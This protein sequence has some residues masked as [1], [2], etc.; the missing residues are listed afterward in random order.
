[1]VVQNKIES[2][3]FPA[4]QPTLSP[5][6]LALKMLNLRALADY[7]MRGNNNLKPILDAVN[8]ST[9]AGLLG[10]SRVKILN[11]AAPLDRKIKS[12]ARNISI[13][14]RYDRDS[15][16]FEGVLDIKNPKDSS[17]LTKR[18]MRNVDSFNC[19]FHEQKR[20]FERLFL[21]QGDNIGLFL[22]KESQD[23]FAELNAHVKQSK[24][25]HYGE[26]VK[27]QLR[28]ATLAYNFLSEFLFKSIDEADVAP[29]LI[30]EPAPYPKSQ[31]IPTSPHELLWCMDAFEYDEAIYQKDSLYSLSETRQT[32]VQMFHQLKGY[33]RSLTADIEH[34][35]GDGWFFDSKNPHTR[36]FMSKNDLPIDVLVQYIKDFSDIMYD[37]LPLEE[38]VTL[39]STT[40]QYFDAY[41]VGIFEDRDNSLCAKV[42]NFDHNVSQYKDSWLPSVTP[43]SVTDVLSFLH[44]K[45][46]AKGLSKEF[47]QVRQLVTSPPEGF[48]AEVTLNIPQEHGVSHARRRWFSKGSMTHNV[49]KLQ[50]E[51]VRAVVPNNEQKIS[52]YLTSL[53]IGDV[54]PMIETMK[55]KGSFPTSSKGKPYLSVDHIYDLD[56]GGLNNFENWKIVS[57]NVNAKKNTLKALQQNILDGNGNAF[58]QVNYVPE[59]PDSAVIL[60]TPKDFG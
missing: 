9:S 53:K 57:P 1:M 32:E 25:M 48:K 49:P 51:F 10:L 55:L 6:D 60:P 3:F 44:D 29:V 54:E 11:S 39:K 7:V 8:L 19:S 24:Y 52:E 27:N 35:L 20:D 33:V 59:C 22:L 34:V 41:V 13:D 42:G 37:K 12:L 16:F 17:R 4:K 14:S 47:E 18:L 2:F 56:S 50:K 36:D 40:Q 31:K 30:G 38:A 58:W 43:P 45:S 21:S 26:L 23:T 15:G 28:S 5:S 46:G